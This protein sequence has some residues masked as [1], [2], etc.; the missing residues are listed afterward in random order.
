MSHLPALLH[1]FNIFPNL[2]YKNVF[3]IAYNNFNKVPYQHYYLY[4]ILT[5]LDIYCHLYNIKFLYQSI[6]NKKVK[7]M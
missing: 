5:F 1:L 7:D 6:K 4:N 2:F 3:K